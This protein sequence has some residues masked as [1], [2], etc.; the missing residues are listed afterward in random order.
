MS[1]SDAAGV[2]EE[3]VVLGDGHDAAFASQD[4]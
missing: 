4:C 2:W 3:D 1:F